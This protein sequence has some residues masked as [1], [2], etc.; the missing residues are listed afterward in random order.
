MKINIKTQLKLLLQ[1]IG[2]KQEDLYYLT[3]FR[4]SDVKT[5]EDLDE[6]KRL[7]SQWYYI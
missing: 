1:Q 3:G 7:L 2:V 5:K 6:V 4:F